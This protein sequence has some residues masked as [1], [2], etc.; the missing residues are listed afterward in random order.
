MAWIFQ[1]DIDGNQCGAVGKTEIV[2]DQSKVWHIETLK[3]NED[4][5][6]KLGVSMA[7]AEQV[8]LNKFEVA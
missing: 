1:D 2:N 7:R 8:H 5:I 4:G 3:L 6:H